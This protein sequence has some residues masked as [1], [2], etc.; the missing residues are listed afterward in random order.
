MSQKHPVIA[1]TGSVGAGTTTVQRIFA[2]IF[3]RNKINASYVH[4]NSFRKY[5][6]DELASIFSCAEKNG[7]PISHFGPEVNLLDRLESLFRE[8]SRSGSGC[9]REY[10]ETHEQAAK[11]QLPI[12]NFSPWTEL[13]ETSDLLFYEGQHGGCTQANWSKRKLS[14]SHNPFV[15]QQRAKSKNTIDTGIDIAQWVDLLIGIAPSINLEWMQKIHRS[16]SI[17]G[18]TAEQATRLILRRMEDYVHYMTPQFSITDINFQRIPIVDTSCPF[19]LDDIPQEEECM[20]VIRFREPQKHDIVNYV[21]Q[22]PN[23]FLSRPNTL[24]VP[25]SCMAQAI[26]TICSPLVQK[27]VYPESHDAPTN[28]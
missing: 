8:Y 21:K 5:P 17:T 24:V 16:C 3:Q 23:A 9:V 26:D 25:N 1:I 10:I 6:R 2:N 12:G 20:L 4:G 28:Q 15:I 14:E 11:H 27:L 22:F 18:C 19:G 7:K 13:P